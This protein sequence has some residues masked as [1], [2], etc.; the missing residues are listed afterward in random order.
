M[1]RTNPEINPALSDIFRTALEKSASKPAPSAAPPSV[2]VCGNN[3][4]IS[5]GDSVRLT[6]QDLLRFWKRA[7]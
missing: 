4:V 3:N 6:D 2:L 7:S 5:F 1:E